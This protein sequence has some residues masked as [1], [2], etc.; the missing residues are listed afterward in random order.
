MSIEQDNITINYSIGAARMNPEKVVHIEEIDTTPTIRDRVGRINPVICIIAA[1]IVIPLGLTVFKAISGPSFNSGEIVSKKYEPRRKWVSM[2]P[3]S[4]G[5]TTTMVPITHVD[6]E[7]YILV[8]KGNESRGRTATE[9]W[10]VS[11]YKYNSYNVG[12]LVTYEKG[13]S[14]ID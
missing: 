13:D 4:T 5:K 6:D 2:S 10:Y 14:V 3:V 11:K 9:K 1:F 7:D 8:V 12:D